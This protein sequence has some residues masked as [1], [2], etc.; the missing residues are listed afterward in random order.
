MSWLQSRPLQ[1]LLITALAVAACTSQPA[2]SLR[3]AAVSEQPC[4]SARAARLALDTLARL[5]KFPSAVY[6]YEPQAD[7][8]RIV[9]WPAESL[10]I[11][12]GMAIVRVSRTCR[13]LTLVQTDSA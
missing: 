12:D 4:D 8:V 10:H 1:S 6:R 2:Q 5:D 11:L 9:T 7:G 13:I 3:S